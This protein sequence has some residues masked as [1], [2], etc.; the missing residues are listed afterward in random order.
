MAIADLASKKVPVTLAG[1][2][3]VVKVVPMARVRQLA[4]VIVE[5]L[6]QV[7]HIDTDTDQAALTAVVDKLLEFPHRL[8]SLF[9]DNLPA[10]IFAD[11][12]N[13]VTFPEFWEVLQIALTVN[14]VDAL[15]NVFSRLMPMMTQARK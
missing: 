9:I 8:L 14:R 3:F 11:E 13:G 6:K 1:R 15:K 12:E 4:D 5:A 2:D 7:E 10:D